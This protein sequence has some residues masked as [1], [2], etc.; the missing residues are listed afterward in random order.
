LEV[1][2]PD[3]A[4]LGTPYEL[5]TEGKILFLEDLG[6]PPYRNRPHADTAASG[7]KAGWPRGDSAREF[8]RTANPRPGNTIEDALREIIETI[9]VPVIANFLRG[10][11]RRT[12][13]AA[14][15]RIRLNGESCSIDFLE[16]AVEA[17]DIGRTRQERDR[18]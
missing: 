15:N 6:E 5:S 16:H 7:T 13:V 9:D 4:S 8:S 14:W 2:I 11:E 17:D 12:G 10:T 18:N 3:R 1:A